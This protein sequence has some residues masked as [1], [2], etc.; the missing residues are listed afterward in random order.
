VRCAIL[1]SA[2]IV[3]FVLPCVHAQANKDDWRRVYT[4]E[5]FVTD[6]AV[7]SLVL[8]QPRILRVKFRTIL[9]KAETLRDQPDKKYKTRI[10]TIDFK[11]NSNE[12]RFHE[13]SLLDEAGKVASSYAP[14]TSETW[15]P[16]KPEGM[17]RRLLESAA[18]LAPFGDWKVANYRFGEGA[19]GT[20]KEYQRLLGTRV[21]LGTNRAEVGTK[22]CSAPAY[23]SKRVNDEEFVKQLGV[24]LRAIGV[25][26]NLVETVAIKCESEGWQPPQSLL[27]RVDS[28]EMLMLWEGIFLVLKR[29]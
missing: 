13:V 11:F 23:Q 2:L 1:K 19:P 5:D 21:R 28:G 3:A 4:A 27:V 8:E 22:I 18:R 15:R 12:Y 24:S 9:S 20:D 29:D 14:G 25:Q 6:V 7:S 26:Q 10:E 17:M 16:Y